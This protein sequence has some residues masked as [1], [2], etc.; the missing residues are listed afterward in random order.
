MLQSLTIIFLLATKKKNSVAYAKLFFRSLSRQLHIYH[1]SNRGAKEFSLLTVG[2][3]M[4]YEAS[5]VKEPE[6]IPRPA[7]LKVTLFTAFLCHQ[8]QNNP[9][10]DISRSPLISVFG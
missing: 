2:E 6:S 8:I 9:I 4:L 3:T 5:I 10:N 1:R 7:T